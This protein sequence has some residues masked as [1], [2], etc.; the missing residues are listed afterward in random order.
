VPWPARSPTSF[1]WRTSR[2]STAAPPQR[3]SFD[4]SFARLRESG[5]PPETL[6]RQ[7]HALRIELVLTAH[8][9][10]VTRRTLRQNV[11]RIAELLERKD[12][13]DLTP[14]EQADTLDGLRREVTAAWKTNEARPGRLTPLDEVTSGL[15]V[16][17][18]TLWD[19]VP[20]Y[21]RALERSLR[22]A[23][24]RPLGLDATPVR[25]GAR[26]MAAEPRFKHYFESGSSNRVSA[27]LGST[28]YGAPKC[29]TMPWS[30][31]EGPVCGRTN[32]SR[33]VA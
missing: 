11:R 14:A 3:A 10:E 27:T 22:A 13:P 6:H 2:S 8:P 19:A 17:E 5:V 31:S 21:L 24:G 9:T 12:H 1:P 32:A 4:D 33:S 28:P 30:R 16:L 23:T 26:W 18:Q 29:K 25:F 15:V 20:D 7:I